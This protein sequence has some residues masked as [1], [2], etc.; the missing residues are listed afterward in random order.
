MSNYF[1]GIKWNKPV[2]LDRC[3]S[4]IVLTGDNV[5][6]VK[7]ILDYI[8][9]NPAYHFTS[10]YGSLWLGNI[11]QFFGIR[12]IDTKCDGWI[13]SYDVAGNRISIRIESEGGPYFTPIDVFRLADIDTD[14]AVVSLKDK[15][16][17]PFEIFCDLDINSYLAERSYP[18]PVLNKSIPAM[19]E[20]WSENP[21]RYRQPSPLPCLFSYRM[22]GKM[23]HTYIGISSREEF[24]RVTSG[25]KRCGEL[26]RAEY[27]PGPDTVYELWDYEYDGKLLSLNRNIYGR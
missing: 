14:N 10:D 21:N 12:S 27:I 16:P 8:N 25:I 17:V 2:Y 18:F 11:C 19:L 26:V 4:S 15:K 6:K 5:E 22:E 24:E 20:E 1:C 7:E 23:F 13:S 9:D 3:S